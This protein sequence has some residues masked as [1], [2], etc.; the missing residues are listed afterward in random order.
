MGKRSLCTKTSIGEAWKV[1]HTGLS[2]QLKMFACLSPGM[3]GKDVV[4]CLMIFCYLYGHTSPYPSEYYVCL[5]KA[6]SD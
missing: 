3:L 5:F 4:Y 1:E 6:F 2:L